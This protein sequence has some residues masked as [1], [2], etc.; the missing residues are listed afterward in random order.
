MREREGKRGK[1]REREVKGH[2]SRGQDDRCNRDRTMFK[3]ERQT[4]R[5]EEKEESEGETDIE[6]VRERGGKEKKGR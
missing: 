6:T 1:E 4:V 5:G 3:Q 2:C